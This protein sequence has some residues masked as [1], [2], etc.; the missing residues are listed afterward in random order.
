MYICTE[1]CLYIHI[2][3][4]YNYTYNTRI[5]VLYQY[6][7]VIIRLLVFLSERIPYSEK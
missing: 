1:Y 4:V 6:R 5:Y 3:I 2:Y 7:A